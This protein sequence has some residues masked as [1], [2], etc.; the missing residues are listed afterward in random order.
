MHN[1]V[2]ATGRNSHRWDIWLNSELPI[3]HTKELM[4]LAH[5]WSTS[6]LTMPVMIMKF[7]GSPFCITN[8][9]VEN[10]PVGSSQ[11]RGGSV[12]SKMWCFLY[13]FS[14]KR[15]PNCRLTKEI[16]CVTTNGTSEVSWEF[17]ICSAISSCYRIN[18]FH[19]NTHDKHNIACLWT[20]DKIVFNYLRCHYCPLYYTMLQCVILDVAFEGIIVVV[21]LCSIKV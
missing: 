19:L 13:V 10:P 6:L 20:Q 8:L 1:H 5:R 3:F 14:T 9:H 15:S 7:H 2:L 11:P 21:W 16:W 4:L 18:N 12:R 17:I